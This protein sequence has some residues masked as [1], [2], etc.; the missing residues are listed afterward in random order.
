MSKEGVERQA[1]DFRTLLTAGCLLFF[2]YEYNKNR[3]GLSDEALSLLWREDSCG[4]IHV[5]LWVMVIH[6]V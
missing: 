5:T 4:T 2:Y 1:H 6:G 3:G